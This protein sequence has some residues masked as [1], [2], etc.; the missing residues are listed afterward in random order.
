MNFKGFMVGNGV[1][2]DFHDYI[3]TFEYWWTHGLISDSTYKN[4]R[5]SCLADSSM[6]PSTMCNRAFDAVD[7]EFGNID[8]YSIYTRP[9]NNT[10][11]MRR[12]VGGRYPWMKRAYDPCTER[13][14]K[15]YFNLPEVQKAL[16]ANKTGIPYP[17]DTCSDIIGDHWGDSPVSML[18]IYQEL[19][20]AGLRIWVFS[21]DTD[22]VVPVTATRYSLDALKLPTVTKWYP[23][24]DQGRVGG[25]S[26]VYKGLTFV[27]IRGAG[28][29]V[30]L[31]RPRQAF[32]LLNQFLKNK[33]MPST[34]LKSVQ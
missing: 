30:P 15:E 32:L 8:P 17:W 6:H 12:H 28:H 33:P 26:E 23:W 2:D 16:H 4:L 20:E 13:Y 3:G 29:E 14:S 1:T 9:C 24:Y 21:G 22:A 31:H 11:E 19:I 27:T 18:P 7:S 10:G 5:N 25:W 34:T